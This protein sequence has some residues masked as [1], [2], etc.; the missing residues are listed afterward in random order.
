MNK[1]YCWPFRTPARRKREAGGERGALAQT[2][3]PQE[4]PRRR[5]SRL[6]ARLAQRRCSR[7]AARV[8]APLATLARRRLGGRGERRGVGEQRLERL[9]LEQAAPAELPALVKDCL[10]LRAQLTRSPLPCEA[11]SQLAVAVGRVEDAPDDELRRDSPVP[12][13]LLQSEGDVVAAGALE[14]VELRAEPEGDR[15]RPRPLLVDHAEAQVL[16]LPDGGE[17]GQPAGGGEKGHAGIAR[18]ERRKPLELR[19]EL[20]GEDAARDDRVDPRHGLEV[21]L[22]E[23]LLGPRREHLRELVQ[24]LGADG[25]AGR[26]PMAAEALE[27]LGAGCERRVEIERGDR[28]ARAFPVP[29]AAGDEDDR[30]V[31][32]L[33]ESRGDD[34]DHALVPALVGE[35][36]CPPAPPSLRPRLHLLER[37]AQ[38]ALLDRLPVAVQTVE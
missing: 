28:A 29:V 2:P 16:A 12:V 19:G 15:A 25:E 32:A 14:A 24:A 11:P 7:R 10:G 8:A 27:R 9:R 21:G 37:T 33:D 1:V 4:A 13:V 34:S 35:H 31:E 36:V 18:A 26:G 23:H 22:A 17:I 30:P 38:D 3:S 5:P 20:E 6:G